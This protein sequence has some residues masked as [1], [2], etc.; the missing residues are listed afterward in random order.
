MEILER[1]VKKHH[2][3]VLKTFRLSSDLDDT[4]TKK[5]A[6]KGIGKNALIV[7]I[8]NK[9]VEWDSVVEDLNYVTLP[10]EMIAKLIS[11]LDEDSLTSIAKQVSKSIASSLPLWY[12]SSNLDTL[13]LYLNTN[14]KYSG[15][16]FHQRIEKQGNS[17]RFIVHQPFSEKGAVWVK[18]FNVGLI[19]S[20]LGYPPKIIEHANSIET[21]IELKGE[22]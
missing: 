9:Y 16:H 3:S 14:I 20:V 10:F 2:P 21:I 17:I 6:D 18:A 4:L 11:C 12:G 5:A 13:L 15:A 1:G 19:G 8:L 22:I 7:S